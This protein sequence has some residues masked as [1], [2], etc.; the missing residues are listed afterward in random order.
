MSVASS[1]SWTSAD[2]NDVE[3]GIYETIADH[4]RPMSTIEDLNASMSG[5]SFSFLS[6]PTWLYL[7]Y[8]L[9]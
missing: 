4:V 7:I 5:M 9:S 6:K 8:V 2:F 1:E 3:A